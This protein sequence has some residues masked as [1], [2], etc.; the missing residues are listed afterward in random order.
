MSTCKSRC[1]L[2]NLWFSVQECIY[3]RWALLKWGTKGY[4]LAEVLWGTSKDVIIM[5]CGDPL[6]T[7][8]DL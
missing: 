8:H 2:N 1:S 4:H 3:T 7:L 6:T 5:E